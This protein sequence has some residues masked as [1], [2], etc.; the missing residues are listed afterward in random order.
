MSFRPK[1]LIYGLSHSKKQQQS[2]WQVLQSLSTPT[3]THPRGAQEALAHVVCLQEDSQRALQRP[4]G[5]SRDGQEAQLCA[6]K[7]KLL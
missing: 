6:R 3:H 7:H 4:A 2:V 5:C 1:N